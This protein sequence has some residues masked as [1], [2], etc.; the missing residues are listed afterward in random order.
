MTFSINSP[1][2]KASNCA[3]FGN[4]IVVAHRFLTICKGSSWSDTIW[5]GLQQYHGRIRLTIMVGFAYSFFVTHGFRLFFLRTMNTYRPKMGSW[6]WMFFSA[7]HPNKSFMQAPKVDKCPQPLVFKSFLGDLEIPKSWE[8]LPLSHRDPP[9]SYFCADRKWSSHTYFRVLILCKDRDFCKTNEPCEKNGKRNY[10]QNILINY[11]LL[12]FVILLW[13]S[14][15][16]IWYSVMDRLGLLLISH[17]AALWERA[18]EPKD[19]HILLPLSNYL[20]ILYCTRNSK[21]R[22]NEVV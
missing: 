14:S 15:C 17:S 8:Q 13:S 10:L 4:I 2:P 9:L 7:Q 1:C 12:Y 3:V 11:D 21:Y 20:L 19:L 18:N 16:Y 6:S 22:K 5:G